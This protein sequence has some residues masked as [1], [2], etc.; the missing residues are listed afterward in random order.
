MKINIL[1]LSLF[2]FIG[3][4]KTTLDDQSNESIPNYSET[5]SNVDLTATMQSNIL[6]LD[7]NN[8][9]TATQDQNSYIHLRKISQEFSNDTWSLTS[10]SILDIGQGDLAFF[11]SL[12]N[13]YLVGFSSADG[14]T[15]HLIDEDFNISLM[16]NDLGSF[17]DT[18]Y[19]DIDSLLLVNFDYVEDNQE[20]LI[21]GQLFS[22]GTSYSC[23][24][25]LDREL[26]PKWIKTYFENSTITNVLSINQDTFLLL[27][28]NE[29]GTDLIRD[30]QAGTLYTKYDLTSDQL[31]FGSQSFVA[32]DKI[33][34]TGVYNEVGRTIEVNLISNTTFINDIDLHPVSD[35]KAVFLSRDNFVTAGIQED[36]A[37]RSQ[38]SSELGSV[39]SKWC[40]RYIDEEYLTILDIIEMPGKGVLISSI[41]ERDSNY[42][43]H[44]T[45][46]DEEGATF[47]NEYSE[48][49]I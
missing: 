43:L 47:V 31:F 41:V 19:N 13:E 36:G 20:I 29:E 44:L 34:L 35:I 10:E 46:I 48:N 5:L 30:N 39:G 18:A 7:D 15:I 42:Y 22:Q 14:Y 2:L 16:N 45:R 32:D 6:A 21:G 23:L 9:I 3:C 40:H 8:F 33:Y 49:C 24:L 4:I 1:I 17:I 27:N 25:S 38:F 11:D 37:G 26:N 12:E 28:T